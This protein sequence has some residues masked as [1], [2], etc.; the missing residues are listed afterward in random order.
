MQ[1]LDPGEYA[2]FFLVLLV[3]AVQWITGVGLLVSRRRVQIVLRSTNRDRFRMALAIWIA[4]AVVAL[5]YAFIVTH[6]P[7]P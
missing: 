4:V 6:P 1:S 5:I 7:G 2:L 3:L